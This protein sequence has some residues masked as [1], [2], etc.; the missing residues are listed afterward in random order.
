MD[1]S[2]WMDSWFN[3]ALL[4]VGIAVVATALILIGLRFLPSC[5][6]NQIVIL[7]IQNGIVLATGL[8]ILLYT[9]ETRK[10]RKATDKTLIEMTNQTELS[11]RSQILN[12]LISLTNYYNRF[13]GV[14][15]RLFRDEK[16]SFSE[17]TKFCSLL[18]EVGQI[19]YE[20]HDKDQEIAISQ[21]NET[22]IRCWIKLNKFVQKKR[23]HSVGRDY[24]YFEWLANKSREDI[25]TKFSKKFKINFYKCQESEFNPS[26][27]EINMSVI[28]PDLLKAYEEIFIGSGKVATEFIRGQK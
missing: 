8:V 6:D 2:S 27:D 25:Q 5:S 19:V 4:L 13:S 24:A 9:I 7:A 16:I 22:F 21:W 15:G 1:D 23:P 10:L 17:C 18:D 20:L 14:R 12:T 3:L 11:R 28:E 26:K